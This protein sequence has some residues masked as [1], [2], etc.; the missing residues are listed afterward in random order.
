MNPVECIKALESQF[1]KLGGEI[2]ARTKIT[3]IM[4]HNGG[5]AIETHSNQTISCSHLIMA[6]GPW[7]NHI[8]SQMGPN[9]I[10]IPVSPIR[11]DVL[12]WRLRDGFGDKYNIQ[13]FGPGIFDILQERLNFRAARNNF[14]KK[15]K[16]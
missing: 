15:K 6:C 1:V 13:H 16:F 12:Y 7:T 9:K 14:Y 8:L 3:A 5:F 10:D 11:V 4:E 2:K